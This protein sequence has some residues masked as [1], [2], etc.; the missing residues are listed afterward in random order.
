MYP[1]SLFSGISSDHA[2]LDWAYPANQLRQGM[3]RPLFDRQQKDVELVH[4]QK[5]PRYIC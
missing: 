2:P 4:L 5:D 1:P 3:T